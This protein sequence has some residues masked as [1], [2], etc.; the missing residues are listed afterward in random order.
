MLPPVGYN[1]KIIGNTTI[2]GATI[3]SDAGN[4]SI[5]GGTNGQYLTTN[6]SGTLSWTTGS[7]GGSNTLAGLHDVSIT[8]SP[9]INGYALTYSNVAAAWVASPIS[10]LPPLY[11]IS[12]GVPS[13]ANCIV[14]NGGGAYTVTTTE[15]PGL[16]INTTSSINGNQN[17]FGYSHPAPLTTPYR[18][19][20]Y[21]QWKSFGGSN[22]GNA[23]VF[24]GYIDT[25]NKYSVTLF[26]NSPKIFAGARYS[27]ANT[28]VSSL[29]TFEPISSGYLSNYTTTIWGI[30]TNNANPI[31]LTIRCYDSNGLTRTF[32][33]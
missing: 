19:A 8:E 17:L 11:D 23:A 28:A 5:Q 24:F 30:Q 15:S 3:L 4:V 2:I 32:P 27:N 10:T 7:G 31:S 33:V 9:S 14:I 26:N 20:T 29:A 1:V 22:D 18:V 12:A 21:L 6:G 16:A 13:L 25:A